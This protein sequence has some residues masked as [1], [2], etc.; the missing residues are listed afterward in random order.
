MS[1]RKIGVLGDVHCQ[2]EAIRASLRFFATEQVDAVVAVGDLIDG[3]G[4]G[5]ETIRLLSTL[6][7]LAVAGNHERWFLAGEMRELPDSTALGTLTPQSEAYL[8]E[9]PKTRE[10]A[11]VAGRLLLCHGIGENDFSGIKPT[12]SEESAL[13]SPG[14]LAAIMTGY[15]FMLNGHTHRPML[16]RLRSLRVINAGTLMP[17]HR[18]LC[19]VIDFSGGTI[20]FRDIIGRETSFAARWNLDSPHE[21]LPVPTEY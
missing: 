11:T 1:L 3:P 5:N 2:T 6:G 20:E 13:Q 9:L 14:M 8:R 18:S 12:D 15:E 10:L 16:R 21:M 7:V 19:S 4:D 17:V